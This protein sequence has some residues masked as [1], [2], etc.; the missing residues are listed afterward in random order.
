MPHAAPV[1]EQTPL[2]ITLPNRISLDAPMVPPPMAMP[3]R[4]SLDAVTLICS[5]SM[6]KYSTSTVNAPPTLFVCST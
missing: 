2:T 4:V 6:R 1:P 3:V 5:L